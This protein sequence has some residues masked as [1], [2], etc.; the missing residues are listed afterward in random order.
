M[1]KIPTSGISAGLHG[2][3]TCRHVHSDVCI[4]PHTQ[5]VLETLMFSR[6]HKGHSFIN[7]RDRD[8]QNELKI[9]KILKFLPEN[10]NLWLNFE[11]SFS[12]WFG[13]KETA[14]NVLNSLSK[15]QCFHHTLQ[16]KGTWPVTEEPW[17]GRA[18]LWMHLH[19]RTGRCRDHRILRC[20]V[21]LCAQRDQYLLYLQNSAH[22]P[23]REEPE[24]HQ[25]V[26]IPSLR[27]SFSGLNLSA[28]NRES[29]FTIIIVSTYKLRLSNTV[30]LYIVSANQMQF[31]C[32]NM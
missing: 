1:E 4:T 9:S 26:G 19:W 23:S 31:R 28:N 30:T 22:P 25:G 18:H 17:M 7:W 2:Q 29:L 12:S 20:P 8:L 6:Q 10:I 3:Y 21:Q 5:I 15:C 16:P 13:N 27:H 14:G 11:I 32:D 24:G